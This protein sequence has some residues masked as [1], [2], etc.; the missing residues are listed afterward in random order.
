MFFRYFLGN[1]QTEGKR[2]RELFS[3]KLWEDDY[4]LGN[5]ADV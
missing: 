4:Y 5:K 2:N 3:T 1:S